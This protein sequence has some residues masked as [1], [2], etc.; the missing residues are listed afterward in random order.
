[1]WR[2]ERALLGGAAIHLANKGDDVVLDIVLAL[3]SFESDPVA[4]GS[5]EQGQLA[6]LANDVLDHSLLPR[7][8][9]LSVF[10]EGQRSDH[11]PPC[12]GLLEVLPLIG[13]EEAVA[14]GEP[15]VLAE[16]SADLCLSPN[17][18]VADREAL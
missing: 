12:L 7:D 18:E 9:K 3:E 5:T 17:P 8:H 2:L 1:M 16:Q 13:S 11:P 14:V 4:G 10:E 15:E 6:G